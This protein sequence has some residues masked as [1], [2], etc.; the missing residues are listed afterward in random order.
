MPTAIGLLRSAEIRIARLFDLA[1]AN[2]SVFD[3]EKW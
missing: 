1:L 2:L 3:T